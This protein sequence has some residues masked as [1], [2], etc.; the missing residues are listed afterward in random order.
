MCLM[1]LTGWCV[2]PQL[3]GMDVAR[4]DDAEVNGATLIIQYGDYASLLL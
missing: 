1:T 4:D 2:C 3:A